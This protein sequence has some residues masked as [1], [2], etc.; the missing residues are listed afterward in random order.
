MHGSAA[1]TLAVLALTCLLGGCMPEAPAAPSVP[2]VP[3]VPPV[4]DSGPSPEDVA[5]GTTCGAFGFQVA[6]GLPVSF[7][8]AMAQDRT[9]LVTRIIRPGEPVTMDFSPA[10]MN[11]VLDAQDRVSQVYCG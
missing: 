2:P 9:D 4:A 10:R 3:P 7:F 5:A 11:V 8:E 6:V 1:P